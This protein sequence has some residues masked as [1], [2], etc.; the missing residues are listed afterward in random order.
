MA[1]AY[2]V[3]GEARA[4]GASLPGQGV[5]VFDRAGDHC[6]FDAGDTGAEFMFAAATPLHEPIV[7]GGPFVMT[8]L[9]QMRETQQRYARG[10]MGQLAPLGVVRG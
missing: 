2:G 5:L 7:Y 10:E 8:T 4:D 3:R 1:F 6:V 9:E